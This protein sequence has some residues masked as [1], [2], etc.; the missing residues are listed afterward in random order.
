L[1]V[2]STTLLSMSADESALC[3]L[4]VCDEFVLVVDNQ[5]DTTGGGG[6]GGGGGGVGIPPTA[7]ANFDTY[8]TNVGLQDNN[9][10]RSADSNSPA[11]SPQIRRDRFLPGDTLRHELK[12]AM[13]T[14]SLSELNFRL[15]DESWA[16]D[17]GIDGG[18]PYEISAGKLLFANYDTL[19]FVAAR[20]I[21]R[22]AAGAEYECPVANPNIK[23]DQHYIQVAQ[24]NIRPAQVYDEMSTMFH[25][26]ELNLPTL[27]ASGCLPAGYTLPVGDS[28]IFQADF[29]FTQ[30]FT[31]FSQNQPP[32]INF[33]STVCG[34]DKVYAWK[35]EGCTEKP[36]SQYSGYLEQVVPNAQRIE[37]CATST[38][39]S[40]FYYA[41]RI[42]R[43]NLFPYEIRPLS[44]VLGYSYSLPTAVELVDSRLQFLRLQENTPL[45]GNTA[46]TPTYSGD[47]IRLDLSTFFANPLDE[48]YEFQISTRFDTTCG[49]SG[50]QFGRTNLLMRYANMCFHNPVLANYF[51]ANPNGYQNG[52]PDLQIFPEDDVLYLPTNNV[53]LDFFLRNNSPLNAPNAW[54]SIVADGNLEDIEILALPSGTPLPQIAG[55]WQLGD[56]PAF[57]QPYLRLRAKNRACRPVDITIRFGW[58]CGQVTSTLASTCGSFSRQIE[59]RPQPP[60]MELVVLAQ[61]ESVPLCAPSGY[62]TFEIYNANEGSAYDVLASVK[63]PVGLSIQPGSAQVSYPAGSAYINLPNPT[64]LPGNIYQW[65]PGEVS[66]T[67][68]ANGLTSVD[69][70]PQNAL[71]IR[72][73]VLA[74]CGFVAN[75]QPI[76][77]A[78]AIQSCGISSNV[79]R[80]PGDPVGLD[81]VEPSYA[82]TVNLAFSST[83]STVGCGQTAALTATISLTQIPMPGDSIYILLPTG[84]SFVSGSYQPIANAPIGPPQQFGQTLQLP[85]PASLLPGATL[86]FNFS[87]RYDDPAGCADK[88]VILQAREQ[89]Q[90]FCQSSNSFCDVYIATGEAILN[91]NAQN[92]DLQLSNFELQ[93]QNSQTTFTANLQNAGTVP[94]TNPLVQLYQDLNGNGQIDPNDPLLTTVSLTTVLA[95]N[96]TK[97]ISGVLNL[98]ASALCQLIARIPAAENCACADRIFPFGGNQIV[99]RSIGLC[100]LQTTNVGTENVPGNTYSWMPTPGLSCTDCAQATY[101]PGPDVQPNDVITLIQLEGTGNC[102]I[103]RRYE[104]QFGGS[105]GIE[106]PNQTVCKGQTVTLE[107]TPGGTYQWSG[108]GVTQ[109]VATQVLQPQFTAVYRVTVTFSGGCTGTGSAVV[110]VLQNSNVDLGTLTTCEGNPVSIFGTLTDEPGTYTQTLVK[111]NGC[112]SILTL[113]LVVTPTQT[114]ET[115]ALCLGDST[116]VFDSLFTQSGVLCREFQSSTNCD[117]THCITVQTI[118]APALPPQDSSFIISENEEVTLDVPDDFN[119][120]NWTPSAGLSC[121]N[122]ADPVA[123]PDT[124]TTFLLVVTDVNGCEGSAEYRVVVYPPCEGGRLKIPNAFT[125]N[126][127]NNNDKFVVV[128]YEG[129]EVV[130]SLTIYSR[131][132]E[133]IY[134]GGGAA[135]AWD[136]TIRGKPA[137][138]DVYVWLLE[139]ACDSASAVRKGEVTLLR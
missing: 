5:C 4:S 19:E 104:I 33:R 84:T 58:D 1:K 59:L 98:P 92:P 80:K 130:R 120:Y 106:T 49:Y 88:S 28:L 119:T 112:D 52:S 126:G 14:G 85:L 24:P 123:S 95:P 99:T 82:A 29:K 87:V 138:A 75:A 122:C 139:V 76:Y 63:L 67:L 132:G 62:F 124:S 34:L 36:M 96:A 133:K 89:A 25:Q 10:D 40:P 103:E 115:R 43:E 32:L 125:P 73:R 41:I 12:L 7:A 93:T 135:A 86:S 81:G 79:L 21:I 68:A 20:L 91:L 129:F 136:G 83:P 94:A 51:I 50:T 44:T 47:S 107:A 61:P 11:N 9:N 46:L 131:W 53:E 134:V 8:R 3:G 6:G 66:A 72:F 31:P 42:A 110:T 48:G 78:E 45:F 111:F 15:F 39:L 121:S 64:V 100:G 17:F 137:P 127:D 56:L 22:T 105:I 97:V 70:D 102:V 16:S 23:S 37:P 109:G 54:V 13:L 116:M 35:L 113:R 27:A 26:F 55:V 71:R 30:N 69:S 128:P 108:P 2:K 57:G 18:D 90:A 74:A 77:G 65:M 60:E 117:S 114:N 38:E 101:T 118:D